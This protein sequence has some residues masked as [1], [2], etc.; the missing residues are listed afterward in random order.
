MKGKKKMMETETVVMMIMLVMIM[1]VMMVE[2]VQ[3][4]G[5]RHVPPGAHAL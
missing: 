1:L 5:L 4:F 3:L 2:G